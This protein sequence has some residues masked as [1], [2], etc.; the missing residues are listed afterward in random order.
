MLPI[1]VPSG[2]YQEVGTKKE[3]MGI[4]ADF[5][6]GF[7]QPECGN[8]ETCLFTSADGYYYEGCGQTSISYNWVTGNVKF[9]G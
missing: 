7:G 1:F 3:A 8:S 2:Q 4:T 6:K 5:G 9:G